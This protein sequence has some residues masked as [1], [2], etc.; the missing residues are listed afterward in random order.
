[1]FWAIAFFLGMCGL[2][3]LSCAAELWL[4]SLL[5]LPLR[6][7]RWAVPL[8]MLCCALVHRLLDGWCSLGK[9]GSTSDYLIPAQALSG[10]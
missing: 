7:M 8:H 4:M 6:G 9:P 10:V 1:M 5:R 3:H 2:L